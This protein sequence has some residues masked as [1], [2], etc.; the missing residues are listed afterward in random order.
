M[1]KGDMKTKKGKIF[2]GSHGVRR[3]KKKKSMKKAALAKNPQENAPDL[4]EKMSDIKIGKQK[5]SRSS[6]GGKSKT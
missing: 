6:S 5:A 3:P 4:Q 2:R 1:G